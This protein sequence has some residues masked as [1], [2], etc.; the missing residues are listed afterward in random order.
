MISDVPAALEKATSLPSIV[1]ENA[2]IEESKTVSKSILTM[3]KTFE[4][5][6]HDFWKASPTPRAWSV[7]SHAVNPADVGPSN[8][9][10]PFCFEFESLNVSVLVALCWGI[11]VH[12]LSNIIQIYELVQRRSSHLVELEDLLPETS[13]AVVDEAK[14][15]PSQTFPT[16]GEHKGRLLHQMKSEGTKLARYICQ[17]M[18][19]H[20]RIDTGTY[21]GH[22]VTYS[23]WSARQ[24]FR[25]HPGHEREWSWLQNMHKMEGPGTRWGLSNMLFEDIPEPLGGLS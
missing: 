7:P 21:G 10:F 22:A 11:S 20:H 25:L 4:K 13:T 23:S 9:T 16:F 12:L 2:L 24:Y 1:N 8:R 18:E 6:H 3:L 5:W 14:Q 15:C 17:S 19:Y